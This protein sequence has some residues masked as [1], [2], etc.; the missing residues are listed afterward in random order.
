[1]FRIIITMCLLTFISV[2]SAMS[3]KTNR[4]SNGTEFHF[5]FTQD[6]CRNMANSWSYS[7]G[8]AHEI[9]D[10]LADG[11]D[12]TGGGLILGRVAAE[13][14]VSYDINKFSKEYVRDFNE[15]IPW[16]YTLQ[17]RDGW[18]TPLKILDA[19]A[20]MWRKAVIKY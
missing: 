11:W 14:K 8:K 5:T 17:R 6:E 9:L 10:C 12:G 16:T 20:G 19:I 3:V 1:M 4:W 2:C 15:P 18:K 7:S 13:L